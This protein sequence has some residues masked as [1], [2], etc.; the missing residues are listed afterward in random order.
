MATQIARTRGIT[1]DRLDALEDLA[2]LEKDP[3]ALV[4]L[5][6]RELLRMITEIRTK[7]KQVALVALQR[8]HLRRRGLLRDC[9]KRSDHT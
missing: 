6:K 9:T 3:K 7:R 2:N 4:S 5:Q 8:Q 1:Q